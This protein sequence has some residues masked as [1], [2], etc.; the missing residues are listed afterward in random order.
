MHLRYPVRPNRSCKKMFYFC[1]IRPG[2]CESVS[3]A[4]VGEDAELNGSGDGLAFVGD[5]QF[6]IDMVGV[7]LTVLGEMNSL[8]EISW[9]LS[10]SASSSRT[11]SSRSVNCVLIS[12]SLGGAGW[13]LIDIENA[14]MIE[15][16]YSPKPGSL[17]S[18]RESAWRSSSISGPRITNAWINPPGRPRRSA[19]TKNFLSSQAFAPAWRA[20]QPA[21]NK[22][23]VEA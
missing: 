2:G 9:M 4:R 3:L 13:G 1:F 10:R 17:F 19:R 7:L 16:R 21:T 14:A 15:S 11:S 18:C 6:A 23:R 5:I 12:L 20:T 8:A 22:H